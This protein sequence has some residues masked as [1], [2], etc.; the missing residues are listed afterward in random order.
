MSCRFLVIRVE[1][2]DQAG[3]P[4][5]PNRIYLCSLKLENEQKRFAIHQTLYDKG[6]EGDYV[7]DNCSMASSGNWTDCPYCK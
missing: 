7:T 4:S 2:I 6:I 1:S 5:S 3:T